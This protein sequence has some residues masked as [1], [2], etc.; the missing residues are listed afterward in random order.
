MMWY[1]LVFWVGGCRKINFIKKFMVVD[2]RIEFFVFI[3]VWGINF[4]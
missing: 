4:Y 1:V 3:K 2:D